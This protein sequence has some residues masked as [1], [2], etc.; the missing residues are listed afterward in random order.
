MQFRLKRL[1]DL[2]Y[3]EGDAPSVELTASDYLL[4]DHANGEAIDGE[5]VRF[6]TVDRQQ[7]HFWAVCR[8]WRS[9]G[10]SRLMWAGKVLTVE[11]LRDLQQTLRVK[12]K[13]V[14]MDASFETSAVYAECAA[15]DWSALHGSGQPGFTHVGKRQNVKRFF[16][17][18]KFAT[19]GSGGKARYFFWSNEGIKDELSR[20]RN[21]GA[22]FWEYPRDIGPF[23]LKQL[24]SEVKRD[25]VNKATKQIT[26][27]YVKTRRDNHIW[28]CEAMQV[29]A[30]M[31]TGV[32]REP[33]HDIAEAPEETPE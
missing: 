31:M 3:T 32:L 22:P 25:V 7:D 30:A 24:N 21:V 17:P 12:D 9:D 16:S 29:C 28:D 19:A 33:G 27:R 6:L 23:Y 5:L 10:S 1:A 20:L 18:A 14:F 11:T 4:T 2:W 13:L 8:A 15:H 26:R